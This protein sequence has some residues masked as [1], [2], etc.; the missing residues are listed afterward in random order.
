M[1]L[2]IGAI[3]LVSMDR[4]SQAGPFLTLFFIGLSIVF[5]RIPQLKG[6]SFT[7]LIFAAVCASMYYPEFFSSV[8]D[9]DLKKL[10]VPLLMLIMF[11]MGTSMSVQDFAGVLKMPKGV[12]IGLL[13]QFSIM[14]IIGFT[15]ATISGLPKEIAAGIILVGCSPSGLASNVMS[16]ISG[17]NLALSLT[18]TAVA[19]LLAPIMTPFLMKIIAGEL[20]PIDF[21][22][23]QWSIT[24]IVILPIIAGLIFNKIAHQKFTFLEKLMPKISMAGIAIIITIITAAGRD[25]L[26]EIGLILIGVVIVH[27]CL[28]YFLGYWVSRLLK[29]DER[30]SRTIA[31]EV[32]MQNSGLASGL[33]LEM[34]RV[35]TMG[36]APSVFGPFMNISGSA[37]ATYWKSKKT[38]DPVSND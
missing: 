22:G 30:S 16:Y 15:L 19:T 14:P 36:L 13:C 12:L 11:G 33:A 38:D 3:A 25:S 6:F 26:L 20:V 21:W 5:G 9:F 17:A 8:G 37:L 10:I 32:G 31:L 29:M 24:K 35:A 4:V 27:N 18:L 2:G 34:G 28:G 7:I 1:L 23:M